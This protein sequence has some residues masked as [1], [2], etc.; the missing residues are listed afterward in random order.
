MVKFVALF[1]AFRWPIR[2]GCARYGR[3]YGKIAST[4]VFLHLR[5][6]QRPHLLT[7]SYVTQKRSFSNRIGVVSK[8]REETKVSGVRCQK[9]GN[10]SIGFSFQR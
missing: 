1:T 9:A 5:Q 4:D 8:G 3:V 6:I 7:A 2:G 10:R